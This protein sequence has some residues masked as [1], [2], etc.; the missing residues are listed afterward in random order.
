MSNYTIV[1]IVNGLSDHDTQ[2]LSLNNSTQVSKCHYYTKH[3]INRMNIEN[4]MLNL[5]SE[6]WDEVFTDGDIDKIFNS[7]LITYLRV[8]NNS[9]PVWKIFHSYYRPWGS[10]G[11]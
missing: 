3:Q 5:S 7:F 10:A 6:T 8:F 11:I 9:F 4:F 2:L 1:P